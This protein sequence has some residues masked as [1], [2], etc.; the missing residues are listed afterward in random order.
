MVGPEFNRRNHHDVTGKVFVADPHAVC[1]EICEVLSR[2]FPGIDPQPI[3][4]AFATF[5]NLYAG[6]LP[7]YLGCET[8][9]HDAQHSLD[10]AL[11]MARLMDGYE[12]T[13]SDA[14]RLGSRRAVLGVITAL[15]HD[16]GYIR[17]TGDKEQH[18]AEFTL[19]HVRRSGDFLSGLLPPLGLGGE[20]PLIE[21]LVHFTGY[22]VSLDNIQ[23]QHHLDRRLG[24]LLGTADLLSQMSDRCYLEKCYQCLYAE[25]EIA[26]LAGKVRPGVEQPVYSSP[27][28]LIRKSPGFL[29]EVWRERLDGYFEGMYRRLAD[30]F[31]GSDPYMSAIKKRR[32]KLDALAEEIEITNSLRR[33]AYC[34]N[35]GPLRLIL[36]L[37][38]C[39]TLSLENASP[40]APR[41]SE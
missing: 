9:Y 8:W 3:H 24:F 35:A 31:R 29:T 25:F 11:A 7:G 17:K 12:S 41:F 34:I 38:P 2:R 28:D 30:H 5:A 39:G 23:V 15:F 13:A 6:E 36:G 14:D 27:D 4:A 22:E 33:E 1:A 20:V 18:G 21:Q 16:A 40:P 26:G 37:E 32:D 10:C 19:Y